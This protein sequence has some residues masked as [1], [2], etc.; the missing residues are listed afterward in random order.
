MLHRAWNKE[1]LLGENCFVASVFLSVQVK[2][3]K[4]QQSSVRDVWTFKN[5]TNFLTVA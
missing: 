2:K 5:Q 1:L 4:Q 3:K